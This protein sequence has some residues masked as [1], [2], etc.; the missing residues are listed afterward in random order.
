MLG[1][2]NTSY[3]TRNISVD[4]AR[5]VT[6]KIKYLYVGGVVGY[7]AGDVNNVGYGDPPA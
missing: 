6:S 1:T 5:D 2:I 3:V 4:T 7:V